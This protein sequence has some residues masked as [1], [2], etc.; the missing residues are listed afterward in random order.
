MRKLGKSLTAEK[1]LRERC[2]EKCK[3]MDADS[4]EEMIKHAE[5]IRLYVENGAD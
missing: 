4:P 2:L 3:Y 5:A 1:E